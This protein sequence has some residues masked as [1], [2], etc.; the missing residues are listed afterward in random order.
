M[1]AT[2]PAPTPEQ[3]HDQALARMTGG[4]V[5]TGLPAFAGSERLRPDGRPRPAFREELRHIDD[6][7][8]VATAISS[9]AAPALLVAVVVAIGHWLA[10]VAAIPV[11]AVLQ[12][13]L[14]ILHH[15]GAHRLLFSSRTWNDRIGITLFGWIAFGTGTHSYRR[16]HTRHHRDE[17]GPK[18]PDFLLYSFYPIPAASLR[19]KLSRDI[20]GVSAYRILK[21]RLTGLFTRRYLANSLRFFAGQAVVFGLFLAAGQPLLYVLLWVLPYVT[22]YQVLNR[23]RAIAEHGGLTRSSDRRETSHHVRQ[24]WL[25]SLLMVPYGIGWHLAH[26]LDSGIPFR[27]LPAY[28]R[29]LEEDG[30]VTPEHTWPSYRALWRALAAGSPS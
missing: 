28:T 14:F 25:P 8:N 5:P 7:R 24:S 26:H 13:R 22:G 2:T 19:R 1:T 20:G 30:Y 10:I 4:M 3:R 12:N 6:R 29:A 27:N 17:F 16:A 11:M 15:E 23:L 9:V 21:P 18:E